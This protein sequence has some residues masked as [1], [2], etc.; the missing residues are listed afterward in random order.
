MKIAAIG[1]RE[2]LSGLGALGT[3][4]YHATTSEEALHI[5]RSIKNDSKEY[6]II[7]ITEK[8]V[9]GMHPEEYESILGTDLP[10]ILTIPDLT[11]EPDAGLEKLAELTK[12]AVGIDIFSK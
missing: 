3:Q 6:G 5:A 4:V 11:S 12:R 9:T 7:F 8:L 1:P 2:L 10:V